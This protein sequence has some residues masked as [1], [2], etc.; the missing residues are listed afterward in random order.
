MKNYL[1]PD[2]ENSLIEKGYKYI[3]GIDEVGRGCWAGPTA[4]GVY[5]YSKDT[6]Y[7]KGVDDS[8]K[9]SVKQRELIYSNLID[10]NFKIFVG[11]VNT[12][13]SIG[14]GRTIESLI[15][16]AVNE[17]NDR[18]NK[19]NVIFLI[20]GQFKSKFADNCSKVIKGDSTYYSIALASILAK[21][22]R[23]NLMKD[24]DV[25][26]PG[27]NFKKHKGY[28]TKEHLNAINTLG[29]C[30]IHRTSYKLNGIN[31]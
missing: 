1:Y 9:L 30:D 15:Q 24:L 18:F 5:I 4:I 25:N 28:G 23:D 12:I 10:D 6:Q 20:D 2:Y 29:Y 27:Y 26:Y 11:E 7:I 22:Y 31:I 8:K 14:I 16:S 19:D 21:V 3:I 13:N 17:F